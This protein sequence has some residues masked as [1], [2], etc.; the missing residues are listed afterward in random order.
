MP[1]HFGTWSLMKDMHLL[2]RL[3]MS[4]V[5]ELVAGFGHLLRAKC[6]ESECHPQHF[7]SDNEQGIFESTDI[8]HSKSND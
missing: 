5:F 6:R 1:Q 3:L 8:G 2:H 4:Y 7:N